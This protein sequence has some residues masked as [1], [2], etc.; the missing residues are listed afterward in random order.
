MAIGVSFPLNNGKIR[1][2]DRTLSFQYDPTE[3]RVMKQHNLIVDEK[4]P[5]LYAW[6]DYKATGKRE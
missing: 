2:D 3:N 6:A 1:T 5:L 4:T